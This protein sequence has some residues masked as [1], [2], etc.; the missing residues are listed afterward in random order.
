[1]KK[2][3][4]L[5]AT[6]FE[7]IVSGNVEGKLTVESS[8]TTYY[9]LGLAYLHSY[10]E[11]KGISVETLPLNYAGYKE[12]IGKVLKKIKTFSPSIVGLNLLTSNRVSSYQL[13]EAIHEKYPKVQIVLGGIHSTIMYKQ[14]VEKYPF[15]IVVLGEGEITFEELINEL[16]KRT[17]RLNKVDG[18]AFWKEGVQRTSPR[19]VIQDLDILPFPKHEL[20]FK[21]NNKRKSASL[22]ST[23]GCYFSCS[24]CCLN[25]ETKRMVRFRSPKNVVDEIE[26]LANAFPQIKEIIIQD[27]SFFVDNER[28]IEICDEIIKRKIKMSFICSGRIIPV[29]KEMIKKLEEANFR[30]VMLGIESCNDEILRRARKGINKKDILNAFK[31]FKNSKLNLKTFLIVGLPGETIDTLNETAK[32]IQRLQKIKYISFPLTSNILVI[33]PGTEVYEIAKLKGIVNDNFWLYDK[34]IPFYTVEHSVDELREFGEILAEHISY[35][36][37]KTLRGFKAQYKLIPDIIKYLLI[38]LNA[39]YIR[40]N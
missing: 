15:I 24:F 28:V 20:Y 22:L 7:D 35:Y 36:K 25:P 40:G 8:E 34:E 27:D 16:G 18:L 13:I 4:L 9:P 11:S 38:R 6:S 3:I 32:F 19:Q 1:M 14:L 30:T 31:L 26:Y 12:C 39:K 2:K 17:S 23:R 37:L 29:S 5:V 21:R 10:L 33:Y